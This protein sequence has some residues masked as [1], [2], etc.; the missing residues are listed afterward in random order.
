MNENK[1]INY[2]TKYKML[3]NVYESK[4]NM[5]YNNYK[6]DKITYDKYKNIRNENNIQIARCK[7]KIQ[8]LES[9]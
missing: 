8:L 9:M 2:I 6:N 3:I 4:T 1:R 7:R 5:T